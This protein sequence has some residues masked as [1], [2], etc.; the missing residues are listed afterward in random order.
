LHHPFSIDIF[1]DYIYGVTYANNIVFRVNKFGKGPMENLTTGINHATDI[2]LYHRYKQPESEF[3]GPVCTC[4]NGHTL[5]NGI[6]VVSSPTLSPPSPP[7]GTCNLQCRNGGSCFLNAHKQPKCRCQPNYRGE[8]CE[9]DQCRDHCHN[10]G[11]C[12]ASSTGYPTCRCPVGFTGPTCNQRTCMDYCLNKGICSVSQ[13]NQP[14]CSCPPGFLGDK[15]QYSQCEGYCINEGTCM[16]TSDGTRQCVCPPKF[17][18]RTCEV[19]KCLYCGNGRCLHSGAHRRG[20]VTCNCTNGRVQASCYT[21]SDFCVNGL[22][23][24]NPRTQLPECQCHS[25]WAGHRCNAVDTSKEP[26]VKSGTGSASIVIP[27]LM[28]LLL[29]LL[30]AGAI[31]WY[32]KR[33]H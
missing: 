18:G 7:A 5:D 17:T 8:R 3:H 27:L 23:S 2:V 19:D 29:I 14:T 4:P 13:G 31:L 21:C 16:Q 11:T 28:L 24:S 26:S 25:G 22:C 15:C 32:K 12:A 6:C 30:L 33:T 20:E 9:V 10:G 1:E